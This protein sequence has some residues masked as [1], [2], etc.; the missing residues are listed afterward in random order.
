ME[1]LK[2]AHKSISNGRW[3]IKADACDVQKGLRESMRGIWEGDE[4]FGDGLLQQ[5]YT[6]YKSRKSVVGSL[7]TAKR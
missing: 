7:G 3:W 5:L 6:E 4:G 2:Q 1:V